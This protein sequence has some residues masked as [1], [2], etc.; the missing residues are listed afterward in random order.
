LSAAVLFAAAS[1][2]SFSAAAEAE[3]AGAGGGGLFD[4]INEGCWWGRAIVAPASPQAPFVVVV[5]MW[6]K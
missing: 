4:G 5:G 3:A 6:V 1:S 2:S